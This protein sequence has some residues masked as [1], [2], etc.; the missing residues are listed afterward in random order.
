M[1]RFFRQ[2]VLTLHPPRSRAAT[3]QVTYLAVPYLPAGSTFVKDFAT[4]IFPPQAISD[5]EIEFISVPDEDFDEAGL[6]PAPPAETEAASG[7]AGGWEWTEKHSCFA[8]VQAF[9]RE[10]LL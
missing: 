1:T 9:R 10:G 3:R 7:G 8:Y 5:G 4:S 6:L 2:A